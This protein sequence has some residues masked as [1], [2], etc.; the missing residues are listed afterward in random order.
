MVD[1][2][3]QFLILAMIIFCL[4]MIYFY[5]RNRSKK[6][7]SVPTIEMNYLMRMYGIDVHKLGLKTVQK[8]ISFVNS[9]IVSIDLLVYY[10]VENTMLKLLVVFITTFV[11]VFILYNILGTRYRKMLYR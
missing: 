2:L 3:Q 10:N 1:F 9:I 8:H 4:D 6:Y 5:F 11:L 7:S